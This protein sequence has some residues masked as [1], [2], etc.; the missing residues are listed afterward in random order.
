MIDSLR[1]ELSQGRNRWPPAQDANGALQKYY[2]LLSKDEVLLRHCEVPS[3][4]KKSTV[5]LKQIVVPRKMYC[6]I[7]QTFNSRPLAAHVGFRRA[8]F[9]MR[10]RFYWKKMYS[11][12]KQLINA[13]PLCN[14]FKATLRHNVVMMSHLQCRSVGE[15]LSIDF[16]GPIKKSNA[17]NSY[18]FTTQDVLAGYP[19]AF[20]VKD[21]TAETAASCLVE[22]FSQGSVYERIICD[23]GSAFRDETL[24]ALVKH[25]N[26][27]LGSTIRWRGD[28][29]RTAVLSVF[30]DS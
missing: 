22:L 27:E 2:Y 18:I 24:S 4:D 25:C 21:C 1:K 6:D 13:C 17:G 5:S 10:K 29:K 26:S 15:L 11:Q 30:I 16:V 3:E 7:L 12:L 19:H 8:Y 28:R 23:R 9:E 20:A 14:T